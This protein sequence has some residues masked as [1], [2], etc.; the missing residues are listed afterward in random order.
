[1]LI[2]HT[3]A[4]ALDRVAID[5]VG[6]L[7]KT[8]S[9]N[10]N[11]LT[12]QDQ[13]TR[14]SFAIPLKETTSCAI[15]DAFIKHY[16]CYFGSPRVLLSDNGSNLV[17][18]FMKRI[19][20][21][22]KIQHIRTTPYHPE[23]NAVIERYHHVLMEYIKKFVGERNNWD[24][25]L[26][27]ATFS[28]NTHVQESTKFS[29]YELVFGRLPRT[30]TS[31]LYERGDLEETYESYLKNLI[32]TLNELQ[33]QARINVIESKERNKQAFEKRVHFRKFRVCDYV[34]LLKGGHIKKRSFQYTGPY[35][36]IYIFPNGN[37]KIQT[38]INKT[39]TVH[40]NRL[41]H[42]YIPSEPDRSLP[43]T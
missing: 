11:I 35:Q 20:K 26:H 27:L 13:L 8:R 40:P 10:T 22:F 41:R 2:S 5:I 3:P 30:P 15:A 25:Y 9:G 43:I 4:I 31:I 24:E 37:A 6:P 14:Y 29:P 19:A 1:M 38:G 16:I 32:E 39:K 23:G 36:I 7:N 42:S 33:G 18:K 28:Y 21:R 34:W 12:V 17:S